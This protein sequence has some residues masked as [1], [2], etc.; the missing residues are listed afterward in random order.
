MFGFLKPQKQEKQL[1]LTSTG[2]LYIPIRLYYK[3]HN[4]HALLTS[5][6]KLKCC[7]FENNQKEHFI[8]SYFK[9]AK[10]IP[11]EVDYQDV[12][13]ELYPVTLAEGY[14]RGNNL[15][16]DLKSLRRSVEIIDFLYH[17]IKPSNAIELTT[18]AHSNY[19]TGCN[20]KEE[21]EKLAQSDYSE[22]FDDLECDD[23]EQKLEEYIKQAQKQQTDT[24]KENSEIMS[25][26]LD[27]M[28]S[29][30][31]YEEQHNYPKYEKSSIKYDEKE[32]D[33]LLRIL[34]L[35]FVIKEK[36]AIEHY[37]GNRGYTSLNAISDIFG[38]IDEIENDIEHEEN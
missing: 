38:H 27:R 12:P 1:I 9:E 22:L 6:K 19:A 35:R 28:M 13:E 31:E 37:D 21:L 32:H 24:N 33:E 14:I 17:Y 30:I 8:I 5:L 7:A 20:D 26:C 23:I 29:D 15:C 34:T 16:I 18:L 4:K 2:E 36:V 3:I 11:L 25:E 10:R